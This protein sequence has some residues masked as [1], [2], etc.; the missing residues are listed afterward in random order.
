MTATKTARL[1]WTRL[2][3]R[4]YVV[5]ICGHEYTIRRFPGWPSHTLPVWELFRDGVNVGGAR[6]LADVKM[7]GVEV[8]RRDL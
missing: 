2:T 7:M 8:A 6:T 5:R 4:S 3:D 1:A